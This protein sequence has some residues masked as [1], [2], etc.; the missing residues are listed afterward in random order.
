MVNKK[1]DWP[2]V[3]SFFF[4]AGDKSSLKEISE[5][6]KIPYQSVRR[7]AAQQDWHRKRYR[8]WIK[9]KYNF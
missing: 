9:E 6:F 5:Q 2:T 8:H 1:Y 4:N 7:Y 3:E